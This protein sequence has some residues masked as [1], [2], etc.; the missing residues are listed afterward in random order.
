MLHLQGDPIMSGFD[1]TTFEF[2]GEVCSP[3]PASRNR[4]ICCMPALPAKNIHVWQWIRL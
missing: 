3:G 2:Q 4:L 1:G